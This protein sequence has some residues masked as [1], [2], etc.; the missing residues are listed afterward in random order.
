MTARRGTLAITVLSLL[1]FFTNSVSAWYG[2]V[3]FYQ[4]AYFEGPKFPWGISKTQRCY[5]LSCWENKASSVKWEGLLTTGTFSGKARI[6]FFT[7]RGCTGESRDWPTND[8]ING[9]KGNY[10]HDFKLDGIND[11]I[12]SFVI[13]ENSKS[14]KNGV[15]TP[16]KFYQDI[17]FEGPTFPWGIS[18]SQRC[19]NLSCWDN[20]AS[21]VKWSGLP[22]SGSFSGKSRIAFFTGKDCTGDSREWITDQDDDTPKDFTQD[23]INDAV[24]SFIIWESNKKIS[25]GFDTPC[26]WGTN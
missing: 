6:A 10:P 26:P 2:T 12:S 7:G 24:S 20:K 9:K 3:T 8:V 18:K 5:N 22:T 23:G 13:W 1:A 25:N 11:N 19:Y 14:I 4:D 16:L 17:D 21:S 15:A